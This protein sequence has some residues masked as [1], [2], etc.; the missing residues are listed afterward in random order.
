MFRQERS[1]RS[2]DVHDNSAILL[3]VDRLAENLFITDGL[4]RH[5]QGS[6]GI[7][8]VTLKNLAVSER[9]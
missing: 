7:Q 9:G 2:L 8:R 6:L 4:S 5:M 3:W 1:T